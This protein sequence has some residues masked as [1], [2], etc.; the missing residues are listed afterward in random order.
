[1]LETVTHLNDLSLLRPSSQ[2]VDDDK[3]VDVDVHVDV[4]KTI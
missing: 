1:M 3:H 4:I 2:G